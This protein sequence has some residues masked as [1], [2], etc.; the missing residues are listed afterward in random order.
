MS[1]RC[2]Y[3]S[4]APRQRRRTVRRHGLQVVVLILFGLG[5]GLLAYLKNDHQWSASVA[6]SPPEPPVAIRPAPPVVAAPAP[7]VS[8]TSPMHYDFYTELPKRQV[9]IP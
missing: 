7:E 9:D 8:A 5:G 1:A 2:D 4:I 3:K 6:A